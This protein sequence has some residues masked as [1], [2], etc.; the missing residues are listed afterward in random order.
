[1]SF[2]KSDFLFF[3]LLLNN[4]FLSIV[5]LNIVD[6]NNLNEISKSASIL[7]LETPISDFLNPNSNS[8]YTLE[9]PEIQVNSTSFLL[10]KLTRNQELDI[11]QNII[12]GGIKAGD[13]SKS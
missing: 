12:S 5:S 3:V 8:Y 13:G 4:I 9:I 10:I 2:V 6:N 11:S 1:M 7:H